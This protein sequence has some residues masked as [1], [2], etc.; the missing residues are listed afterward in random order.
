MYS[1]IIFFAAILYFID[2]YNEKNKK[3]ILNNFKL[4][5]PISLVEIQAHKYN[6]KKKNINKTKLVNQ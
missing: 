6:K 3:L 4:L 2:F 5:Q 1:F